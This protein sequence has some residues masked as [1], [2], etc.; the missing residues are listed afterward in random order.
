MRFLISLLLGTLLFIN[1]QETIELPDLP[2]RSRLMVNPYDRGTGPPPG[3]GG[4]HVALVPSS[5]K[6]RF[7]NGDHH[8]KNISLETFIDDYWNPNV[9]TWLEDICW[10]TVARFNDKNC[11]DPWRFN[12]IY[13]IATIPNSYM[14]YGEGLTRSESSGGPHSYSESFTSDHLKGFK[15]AVV[16]LVGWRF[17]FW[18][19]DDHHLRRIGITINQARYFSEE[20]KI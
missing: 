20:G 14:Y 16:V 10:R 5:W 15:D 8:I 17:G 6:F 9:N 3:T 1:C 2:P 13:T 11:D 7:L 4:T 18:G 12:V 19:E